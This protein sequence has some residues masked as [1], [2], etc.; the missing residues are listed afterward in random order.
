MTFY[1]ITNLILSKKDLMCR[2]FNQLGNFKTEFSPFFECK[3]VCVTQ[4]RT[5]THTYNVIIVVVAVS[6][7]NVHR[8]TQ[9]HT[10]TH[11]QT[12]KIYNTLNL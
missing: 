10:H 9:L 6:I 3:I 2:K 12:A 7:Q 4:T 1:Y 11:T 5:H 8:H